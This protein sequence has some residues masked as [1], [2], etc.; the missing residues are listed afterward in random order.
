MT[1]AFRDDWLAAIVA[2]S[3]L[4]EEEEKNWFL[5][6]MYDIPTKYKHY[7]IIIAV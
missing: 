2:F 1:L 5:Y 4:K 6:Q 7:V 3:V